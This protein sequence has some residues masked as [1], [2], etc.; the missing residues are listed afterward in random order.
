MV[1]NWV[2][3]RLSCREGGG[4]ISLRS[5]SSATI[6]FWGGLVRLAEKNSAKVTVTYRNGFVVKLPD[7]SMPNE[8]DAIVEATLQ[9]WMCDRLGQDGVTKKFDTFEDQLPF[10]A[11]KYLTE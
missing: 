4:Y 11:A 9:K 6:S 3:E 5:G 8:R 10:V 1:W 7:Q 2:E